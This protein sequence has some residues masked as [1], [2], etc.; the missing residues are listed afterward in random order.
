M[1]DTVKAGSIVTETYIRN[2]VRT[3]TSRYNDM[4]GKY[5]GLIDDPIMGVSIEKS[6]YYDVF[7][8]VWGPKI[9]MNKIWTEATALPGFTCIQYM[10]YFRSDWRMSQTLNLYSSAQNPT[11]NKYPALK[12]FLSPCSIAMLCY[13]W[14]SSRRFHRM[15]SVLYVNAHCTVIVSYRCVLYSTVLHRVEWSFLFCSL[16]SHV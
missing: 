7:C 5:T 9:I 12:S 6:R 11:T 1:R 2:V 4:S 15:S 3:M 13:E 8:C 16:L 14:E 10:A